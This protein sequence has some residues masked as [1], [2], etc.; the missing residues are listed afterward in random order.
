[1]ETLLAATPAIRDAA[2][3]VSAV[4]VAD[5][6]ADEVDDGRSWTTTWLGVLLMALGLVSV[7]GSSRTVRASLA[8]ARLR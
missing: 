2:A 4:P 6:T 1:V 5:L 3:S 8:V 7:L